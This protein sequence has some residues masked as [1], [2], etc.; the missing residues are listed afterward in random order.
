MRLMEEGERIKE[1]IAEFGASNA[2]HLFIIGK[3]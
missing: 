3:K 1:A 2:S